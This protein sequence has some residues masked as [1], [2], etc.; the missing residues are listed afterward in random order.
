MAPSDPAAQSADND[1]VVRVRG[2]VNRFG[3]QIV[4]NDLSF[5][6][7]RNEIMG[8]VGG[9]GAGKSVL[10]HTILGLREP[11][12]GT[13]EVFGRN[14][15]ELSPAERLAM[16][17]AYGVTFQSGALIS[18]LSVAENIQLPLR[19]A[20]SLEETVLDDLVQLNLSLVGLAP[21][22]AE[23][24][25][26]QLSG[27]MVKRAA[28]ARAL[29][30]EPKLLFLD[31]PTSGLDPISAADFDALLL[32]LHGELKLTVVMITHDLDSLFR[33][34]D[35]VSVIVD[36]RMV[37]DTLPGILKSTNPWIRE[38]FHGPRAHGAELAA[39]AAPPAEAPHG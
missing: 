9:S 24:Y 18:S 21:D 29:S 34:C 22:A 20:Y 10:L 5:E 7:R 12:A 26:S 13:V 3:S 8:I 38:Y 25:P 23:K 16:T 37:S 4:H 28:L 39:E 17:R 15:R 36:G 32:Y 2:L 30:L 1:L 14:I 27:G 19:E 35:R 6:V 31:E 33:T 11:Q